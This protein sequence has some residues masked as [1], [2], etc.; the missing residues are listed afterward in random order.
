MVNGISTAKFTS[1]QLGI[2]LHL[3]FLSVYH[4]NKVTV[5]G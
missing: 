4:R 1:T 5:I 3:L 2:D